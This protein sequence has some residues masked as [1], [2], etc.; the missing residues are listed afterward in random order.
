MAKGNAVLLRRVKQCA[1][2]LQN[3]RIEQ[4]YYGQSTFSDQIV[5]AEADSAQKLMALS[6]HHLRRVI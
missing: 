4:R 5:D 6:L 1:T 2:G 3:W